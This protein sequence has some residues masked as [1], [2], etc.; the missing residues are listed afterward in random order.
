MYKTGYRI[1]DPYGTYLDLGSP[2]QLTKQ[3]VQTLKE[4]NKGEPV[5]HKTIT[6]DAGKSFN[7]S[8]D[9]K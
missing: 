2:D 3:Q 5:M 4:K 6:I 1:N 8:F 7:Q 9:L